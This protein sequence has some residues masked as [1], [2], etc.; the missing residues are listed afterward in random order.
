M[1]DYN[2]ELLKIVDEDGRATLPRHPKKKWS[3]RNPYLIKGMCFHQSM[4]NYGIA[5]GNA[6]YDV[7]PNHISEDGLPSLSYTIFVEKSGKSI[8]V[9]NVEDK[10]WSQGCVDKVHLD[11]NALFLAVCFGGNFSGEGYV[12][13][14][15]PTPEQI[16]TA[17]KLW[18]GAKAI[19]GW[20][21]HALYGHYNFGKPACPG[22]VLKSF[23]ESVQLDVADG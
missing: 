1:T 17:K 19:W 12:G 23:I 13:T 4:E 2:A 11:E 21:E 9:N 10:T 6:K 16:A 22:D 20:D 7:G 8:L 15:E 18:D 14:Q 5:S 3:Y